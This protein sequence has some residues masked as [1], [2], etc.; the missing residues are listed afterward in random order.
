ME[1][2]SAQMFPRSSSNWRGPALAARESATVPLGSSLLPC[3]V[4][5]RLR[6]SLKLSDRELQIVQG[7]F[8]DQKQESIAF[9]LGISPHSVNTYIQRIYAKLR[10]CSRPQLIIRV[11]SEYLA[12]V[13]HAQVTCAEAPAESGD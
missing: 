6:D 8:E 4:W 7:I 10:I 3:D 11:M 5:W 2:N 13:A 12:S 1:R 9:G